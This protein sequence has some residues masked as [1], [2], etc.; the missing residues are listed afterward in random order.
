[1]A[2]TL[3]RTKTILCFFLIALSLIAWR[4]S[5]AELKISKSELSVVDT[6]TDLVWVRDASLAGQPLNWEDAKD[7]AANLDYDGYRDWRLPSG[8]NADG[9]V[10]ESNAPPGGFTDECEETDLGRL[11]HKEGISAISPGPFQNVYAGPY[12]TMSEAV[13]DATEAMQFG[14]GGFMS[15][16]GQDA[17]I[18]T[19]PN[20]P[21][22]VRSN[23]ELEELLATYG[24]FIAV[25]LAG[26]GAL[27]LFWI[28]QKRRQGV[29]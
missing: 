26:A 21:W 17:V 1:M 27:V 2:S 22:A 7:W 19:A 16:G 6:K 8:E 15:V 10:C 14:M 28:F 25:L 24:W 9:T 12:W 18:K 20:M 5:F 23:S 29:P 3:L 13:D 11:Y 4:P